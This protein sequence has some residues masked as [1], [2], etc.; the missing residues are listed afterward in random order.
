MAALLS[1]LLS[2]CEYAPHD[3]ASYISKRLMPG[4]SHLL[5]FSTPICFIASM[6]KISSYLSRLVTVSSIDVNPSFLPLQPLSDPLL[7]PDSSSLPPAHKA[8][9]PCCFH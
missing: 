1:V 4:V 5:G 2:V 9:M 7:T 6:K 3:P 8:C